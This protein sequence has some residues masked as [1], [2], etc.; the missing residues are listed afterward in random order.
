M[1]TDL[2]SHPLCLGCFSLSFTTPPSST[3][4]SAAAKPA[5]YLRESPALH[6]TDSTVYSAIKT[7]PIKG[8]GSAARHWRG[9]QSCRERGYKSLW[10]R[11]WTEG[12]DS[13]AGGLELSEFTRGPSQKHWWFMSLY[14]RPLGECVFECALCSCFGKKEDSS[15]SLFFPN[16]SFAWSCDWLH[17]YEM[18]L[19][20][21]EDATSCRQYYL[22]LVIPM[23][24]SQ[25]LIIFLPCLEFPKEKTLNIW[26]CCN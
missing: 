7:Q 6:L 13:W 26:G 18:P 14:S 23:L 20:R 17:F 5:P 8:N 15:F 12:P 10:C 2:P 1:Q 25:T 16:M 24:S 19:F 22:V 9:G 21:C 3:S 4:T 11:P